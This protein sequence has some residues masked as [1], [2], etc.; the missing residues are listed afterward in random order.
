MHWHCRGAKQLQ[1]LV[2]RGRGR[3]GHSLHCALEEPLAQADGKVVE[4]MEQDTG[5]G[6]SSFSCACSHR[7]HFEMC[8]LT[9]LG[10]GQSRPYTPF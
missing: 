7:L 8:P 5:G 9:T 10:L 1:G 6:E 2:S 3:V 4:T